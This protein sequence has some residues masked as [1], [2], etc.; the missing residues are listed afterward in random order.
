MGRSP[1][2]L[3]VVGEEEV[4]LAVVG[5][6]GVEFG[7]ELAVEGGNEWKHCNFNKAKRAC[8]L[9]GAT[10]W[11]SGQEMPWLRRIRRIS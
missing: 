1:G 11:R 7:E 4:G 8:D 6:G 2:E 5:G 10:S 3:L 9:S